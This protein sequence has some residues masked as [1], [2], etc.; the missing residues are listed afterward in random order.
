MA[1]RENNRLQA[2]SKK[3]EKERR[4]ARQKFLPGPPRTRDSIGYSNK[5]KQLSDGG[6]FHVSR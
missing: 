2:D 4:I 5:V 3:E 6:K 1:R